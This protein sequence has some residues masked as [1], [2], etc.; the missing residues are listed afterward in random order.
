MWQIYKGVAAKLEVSKSR[1]RAVPIG[2]NA[3]ADAALSGCVARKPVPAR[4]R[5]LIPMLDGVLVTTS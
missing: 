2:P 1:R 4:R 5:T 3:R